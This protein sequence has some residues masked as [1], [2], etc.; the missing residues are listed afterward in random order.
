[1]DGALINV[2]T[3]VG[4]ADGDRGCQSRVV[5]DENTEGVMSE[6]R[7]EMREVELRCVLM[8]LYT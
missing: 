7:Q 4:N 6:V 2:I 3:M 1:M 8:I 5:D